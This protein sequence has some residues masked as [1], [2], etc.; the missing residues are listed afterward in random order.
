MVSL[1]YS[2]NSESSLRIQVLRFLINEGAECGLQWDSL[3]LLEF[4]AMNHDHKN[5]ALSI[6]EITDRYARDIT[7]EGAR[8]LICQ[9]CWQLLMHPTKMKLTPV[10]T[11]RQRQYLLWRCRVI[12]TFF[13]PF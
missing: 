2:G 5:A 6:E 8:E 12:V 3:Q 13:V 1:N 7:P 9:N 11:E 4:V 10:M